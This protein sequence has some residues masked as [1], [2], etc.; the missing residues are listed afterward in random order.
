LTGAQR[1]G[2]ESY[3]AQTPLVNRLGESITVS[4]FNMYVRT[5]AYLLGL[6]LATKT[7][8]PLTPGLSSLG[9]PS[10]PAIIASVSDGISFGTLGADATGTDLTIVQYGPPV[11][12]GTNFFRTPYSLFASGI[13]M[14]ATGFADE[15]QTVTPGRYGPLVVGQLR[16][17]RIRSMATDGKLSNTVERIVT[18]VA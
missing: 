15:P 2:W 18:V 1:A 5:N 13:T 17:I 9:T 11:S 4:G 8:A 7:N 12:P 10:D 6:A 3:A 14:V 16:P